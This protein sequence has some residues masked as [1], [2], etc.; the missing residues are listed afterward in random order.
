MFSR[1]RGSGTLPCSP[2]SSSLPAGTRHNIAHLSPTLSSGE[3]WGASSIGAPRGTNPS[4]Q[5]Q[6]MTCW[7]HQRA[8]KLH[9][10]VDVEAQENWEWK[11]PS[12]PRSGK[13]FHVPSQGQWD[14]LDPSKKNGFIAALKSSETSAWLGK[15]HL[16]LYLQLNS[17]TRT[18]EI[19][20]RCQAG[21]EA[22]RTISP[23]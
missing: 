8:Q 16:K 14:Q 10:S 3:G 23:E 2:K 15:E 4:K 22:H 18:R 1:T 5:A 20:G 19:Q 17:R 9:K 7:R 11:E 21:R 12:Q 6:D 13:A